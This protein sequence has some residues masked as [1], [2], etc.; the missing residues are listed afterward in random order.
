MSEEQK[1]EFIQDEDFEN[2]EELYEDTVQ[3]E[4]EESEQDDKEQLIEEEVQRRLKE[5]REKNK[6]FAQKRLEKKQD[7]KDPTIEELKAKLDQ[8]E[9][10]IE[11][12]VVERSFKE[13]HNLNDKELE[14]L[15]D[16][17]KGSGKSLDEALE[18]PVFKAYLS[19]SSARQRVKK[20][21]S[22]PSTKT[23]KSNDNFVSP[24][25]RKMAEL[26]GNDPKKVYK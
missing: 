16:I 20:A 19:D 14:T 11:S 22:R 12:D 1:Q 21:I 10:K 6:S 3:E 25:Q 5:I 18:N 26:C 4:T 7:K 15:R 24:A 13:K 17:A 9:G 2:T 8:L 23:E